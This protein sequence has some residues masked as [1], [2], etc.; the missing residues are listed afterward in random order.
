MDE[1]TARLYAE[2]QRRP[3]HH[4]IAF[5]SESIRQL[6]EDVEA[7]IAT[8][9]G[10]RRTYALRG[11]GRNLVFTSPSMS[12]FANDCGRAFLCECLGA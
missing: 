11:T 5:H 7:F 4:G 8:E 3:V 12:P 9:S 10:A 1:L 6:S 2:K